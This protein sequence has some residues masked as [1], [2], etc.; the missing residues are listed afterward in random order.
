MVDA[1]HRVPPPDFAT[2]L[3]ELTSA[4]RRSAAVRYHMTKG[5]GIPGP[6]VALMRFMPFWSK[7]EAARHRA[8]ERRAPRARGPEPPP[9]DAWI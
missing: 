3:E 1:S 6:M 2:R 4:C 5:M 9:L 8:A 7:L